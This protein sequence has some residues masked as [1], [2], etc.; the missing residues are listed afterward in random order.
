MGLC[1]AL[2]ITRQSLMRWKNSDIF[3]D[4]ITHA[5]D[6]VQE[7]AEQRLYDKDGCQ[8]AK[9]TLSAN[10]GYAEKSEFSVDA[11]GSIDIN[12]KYE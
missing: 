7:Y 6:K 12:L 10:F 3:G 4:A 1:I 11:K 9:F 8:G 2:N 5:R